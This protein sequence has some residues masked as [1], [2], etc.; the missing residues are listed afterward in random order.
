MLPRRHVHKCRQLNGVDVAPELPPQNPRSHR[1]IFVMTIILVIVAVAL[2][3]ISL[4]RGPSSVNISGFVTAGSYGTPI[5]VAFAGQNRNQGFY[6]SKV[7]NGQYNIT[8]P[9]NTAYAVL[10]DFQPLNGSSGTCAPGTILTNSRWG[11][12]SLTYNWSC[13]PPYRLPNA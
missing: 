8:V 2:P 4:L 12:S 5:G 7:V 3:S 9:N 11:N 6:F 1:T 13:F 10:I